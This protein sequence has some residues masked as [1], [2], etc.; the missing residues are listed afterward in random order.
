MK[1]LYI[2]FDGVI[3]DTIN[4]MYDLMDELNIDRNNYEEAKSSYVS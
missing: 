1:N 4:V 3:L 2:D